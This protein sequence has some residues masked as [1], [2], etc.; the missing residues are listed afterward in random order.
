MEK[1]SCFSYSLNFKLYRECRR[2]RY[3]GRSVVNEYFE[4]T[5]FPWMLKKFHLFTIFEQISLKFYIRDL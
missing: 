2:E 1:V 3:V 4:N 5:F